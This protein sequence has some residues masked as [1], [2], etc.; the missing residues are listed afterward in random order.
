[1]AEDTSSK[2]ARLR[3]L[4]GNTTM[5]SLGSERRMTF[6]NLLFEDRTTTLF[7]DTCFENTGAGGTVACRWINCNW[8][9]FKWSFNYTNTGQF[10]TNS[11]QGCEFGAGSPLHLYSGT[12]N[13]LHFNQCW[14]HVNNTLAVPF[15]DIRAD[16]DV[17]AT[18]FN[19]CYAETM[20]RQF[21]RIYGAN[22]FKCSQTYLEAIDTSDATYTTSDGKEIRLP[23]FDFSNH[24]EC[25]G[26]PRDV[27]F[28]GVFWQ[29]ADSKIGSTDTVGAGTSIFFT[30]MDDGV[31]SGSPHTKTDFDLSRFTSITGSIRKEATFVDAFDAYPQSFPTP[32]VMP[33]ISATY[34]PR[35]HLRWNSSSALTIPA[36]EAPGIG[37][38][39][40]IIFDNADNL[41]GTV[42]WNAA[43]VFT[44]GAWTN[45]AST[46]TKHIEFGYSGYRGKWVEL[47]RSGDYT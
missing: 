13:N 46:K 17:Q 40:L 44:G 21:V 23:A 27:E 42:T 20:I 15:V 16:A 31:F 37:Q 5:W 43:F 6:E 10:T 18:Y 1:V 30:D 25:Q 26:Y 45:P 29:T 24:A 8:Y 34:A 22:G 35:W 47:Y 19:Q 12:T 2:A 7:T 36:P 28:D 4:L 32:G 38:R 11:F 41:M 3:C 33:Y 14:F 9:Y 39:L